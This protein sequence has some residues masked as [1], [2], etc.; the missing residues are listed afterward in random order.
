M[1]FFQACSLKVIR[2]LAVRQSADVFGYFFLNRPKSF[3]RIKIFFCAFNSRFH[4][5][6]F[7]W[8]NEYLIRFYRYLREGHLND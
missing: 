2:K 5:L 3:D 8:G 4:I 6:Q 1:D 7:L